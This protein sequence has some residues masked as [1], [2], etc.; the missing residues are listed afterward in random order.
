MFQYGSTSAVI[1]ASPALHPGFAADP[2]TARAVPARPGKRALAERAIE[3]RLGSAM[4]TVANLCRWTGMSRSSLYRLFDADGGVQAYIRD[5]RLA[6][7]AEELRVATAGRVAD[8]A[9]RWGFC[10][11]A[12]LARVFREVHGVTPSAYRARHAG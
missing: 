3:E 2:S 10:D 7:V 12:Y 11:A 8:I 6:R 1:P 5:Q 4:L 9:E